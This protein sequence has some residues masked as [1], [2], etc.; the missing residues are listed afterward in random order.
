MILFWRQKIQIRKTIK[1]NYI[2]TE[3][4]NIVDI[5]SVNIEHPKTSHKL[6]KTISQAEKVGSNKK[7][8]ENVLNEKN[9]K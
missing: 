7:K 8:S 6:S 5:K 9:I 4:P 2:A 1:N 3:K